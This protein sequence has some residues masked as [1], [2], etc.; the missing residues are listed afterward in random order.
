[1]F[2]TSSLFYFPILIFVLDEDFWAT[3]IV[4]FII[5]DFWLVVCSVE[6]K[7]YFP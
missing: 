6:I 2:V 5:I 1:M 4:N 3:I 7:L